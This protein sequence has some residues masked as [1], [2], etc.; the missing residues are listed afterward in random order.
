M[1]KTLGL[2][3]TA[4]LSCTLLLGC[5][6][7]A[8]E[9]AQSNASKTEAETKAKEENAKTVFVFALFIQEIWE[10]SHTMIPVTQVQRRL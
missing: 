4:A 9:V 1:K 6:K 5:G 8:S 2:I 10:T 7:S 3:L